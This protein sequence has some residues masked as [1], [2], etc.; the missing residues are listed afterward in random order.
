MIS[1]TLRALVAVLLTLCAAIGASAQ[2]YIVGPFNNWKPDAPVEL[3]QRPDGIYAGSVTFTDQG[4]FKMSTVK[5]KWEEFDTETLVISG[6]VTANTWLPLKRLATSPNVKAP[7]ASTYTVMV[8]LEAMKIMFSDGGTP[9][10]AWSQTLPLLHIDTENGASIVDKETYLTATYYL[11]SMGV[12]G[13]K[14]IGSAEAPLTTQIKGRG[15]YS[16]VGFDKKPYRLKLTDKQA[17]LGMP[18][19]KH[20]ALLAHADDSQGLHRNLAGSTAPELLGMPWTPRSQ[21]VEV[22]LNGKYTGLYFLTETI[23]VAKDRVNITEQADEATTDVDGG[24]L[25]EIDN[26]DTDPNVTVNEDGNPNMPVWFT[27]KSPEVLSTQQNDYLVGQMQAIDN[28]IYASDKSNPAPLEALVDFDVLA[29]YYICQE[30]LDDCES[31]HGSCYLNRN[32]GAECKWLFGPV[33]DF[34]NALG[35]GDS[36]KFI[37]QNP[38]FHQ[39]WIG[40]IYKYPKF[41]ATVKQVWSD[42]LDAHGEENLLSAMTAFGNRIAAAAACDARRWPE[43]GNADETVRTAAARRIVEQK[44]AWLKTQWGEGAGVADIAADRAADVT[45]AVSGRDIL[46]TAAAD[47]VVTI[48]N[49]AGQSHT[50]TLPAGQTVTVTAPAPGFYIAAGHK[51]LVK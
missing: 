9:V 25:V 34:G 26:Y 6:D 11:E 29:R 40:E 44:I 42:F 43:Y 37:W 15:N 17:L 12:E 35:R 49:I 45:V 7:S 31:F 33:W 18:S 27:Y 47:T 3:T 32:R 16:W 28:A 23:R 24:W 8:D 5:G 13:V 30:I 51:V 48:A 36:Q 2:V 50:V 1:K 22:V 46:L 4:Q 10:T 39:V 21:P 20:W 19:S 41:V 14:D 38:P